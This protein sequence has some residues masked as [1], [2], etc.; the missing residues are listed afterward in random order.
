MVF[1][2]LFASEYYD[3][4]ACPTGGSKILQTYGYGLFIHSSGHHNIS[5]RRM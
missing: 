4:E 1:K 5:I 2:G 3:P